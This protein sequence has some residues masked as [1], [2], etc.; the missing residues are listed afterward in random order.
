MDFRTFMGLLTM[1]SKTDPHP[2]VRQYAIKALGKVG[3]IKAVS[4]I[5]RILT[6]PEEKEYN[7]K[8]ASIA[9]RNIRKRI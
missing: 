7:H 8:A 2:Q 3:D 4:Y 1:L 9:I 6:N 5:E